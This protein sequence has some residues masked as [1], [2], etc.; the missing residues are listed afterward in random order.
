MAQ[1]TTQKPL[2]SCLP[3]SSP[4][5]VLLLSTSAQQAGTN[6]IAEKAI[7]VAS[8]QISMQAPGEMEE[9]CSHLAVSQY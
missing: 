6:G 9:L 7:C 1:V 8:G 5:S 3:Y 2:E 4:N